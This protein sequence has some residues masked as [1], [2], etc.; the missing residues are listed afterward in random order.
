M[1]GNNMTKKVEITILDDNELSID[2]QTKPA[3]LIHIEEYEDDE[4]VGGSYATYEN[5]SEKLKEF[6]ND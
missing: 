1:K 3:G 5:V 6:F 2:G 4:L